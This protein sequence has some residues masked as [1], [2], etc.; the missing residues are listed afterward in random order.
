MNLSDPRKLA[1][2]N[3][4]IISVFS[5][6]A[7]LIILVLSGVGISLFPLL[8]TGITVFLFVY[9]VF[10]YTIERFIYQKI[11]LV[12][13]TISRFKRSPGYEKQKS[14]ISKDTIANVHN[15]V[16]RWGEDHQKE[17]AELEQMAR[18]RRE[19]LGNISHELKTPIFNIQGYVLT[20]LDGGLEDPSINR[21]Y[22]ER[23]E[24]SIN[25]LIT[26]VDD[27]ENISNL[28]SGIVKLNLK[29]FDVV[30][31]AHEVAEFMEIKAKGQE[32]IIYFS[33]SYDKPIIVNADQE[34]IRQIF[35]NL[36]D[37]SLKYGNNK[38]GKTKISFFDMDEKILV[39]V[40]DNGPGIDQ[41]DLQRIFERFYRTDK[42][43]SREQGGSGLGL[44]IVKHIISAHSQT[45]DVR[46]SLGVGTTFAFT[47]AKG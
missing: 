8:I 40:T 27:L 39:E 9:F 45:I 42:S 37:N 7:W 33:E 41:N 1:F 46:S 20:L 31:L 24:K 5:V 35:V 34:R 4:L 36:I 10:L 6:G 21:A 28:E 17:I 38:G 23:T 43:R 47:L 25:R 32:N 29:N 15:E 30:A 44:S 12:Y 3:A 26:I 16:L 13:K 19:F 14:D 18:Y 22:L 2:F 11:K